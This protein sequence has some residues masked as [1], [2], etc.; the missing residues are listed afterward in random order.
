MKILKVSDIFE[1]KYG[2]NLELVHLE[3][4]NQSDKN[5]IPFV[6]RTEK[7]NGVSA[8]VVKEVDVKPNPAYS[9]SVA[10]GGS[11][12]STF[13][14][15]KEYYSGRDI[16]ILIPKMRISEIEMLFYAFCIRKNKY[17]YN[18][19]RQA[20]KTLKDILIPEK[21]PENW[22]NLSIKKLNDLNSKPL[23]NDNLDLNILR[24][25]SFNL[26]S[27]FNIK[28]SVT[29]SKLELEE[30]G[31]G[32][33]PYVTTQAENNGVENSFNYFTEEG[34]ILTVDSAVIGFC[35]YQPYNFSA[36]DHVEKLI[37]K[38]KINKYIAM[39]LVTII[40]SEQY[41]YNYGRKCSQDRMKQRSVMLPTKNNQPDW[42]FMEDYIK[43]L[44]YSSSL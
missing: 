44:P 1:V 2:I 25:K 9:I 42:Q 36:S 16:Y 27:I 8:Y 21:M 30:N 28:G 37:P 31:N 22:N 35:S 11:V 15:E 14:Q 17:R 34:N 41:R 18:Y 40:N 6:S 3:E 19:G 26:N 5:S 12:L 24:W 32:K 10:G 20:N 23:I 7:N 38:F 33:F 13:F 39:F 29:T 43:S 4:C